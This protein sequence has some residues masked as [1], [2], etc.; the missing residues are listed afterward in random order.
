MCSHSQIRACECV[1]ILLFKSIDCSD[2]HYS[3]PFWER[4]RETINFNCVR[5]QNVTWNENG[6]NVWRIQIIISII[7][8]M[9]YRLMEFED[10]E[11]LFMKREWKWWNCS[12]DERTFNLNANFLTSF[13]PDIVWEK[14]F[15]ETSFVLVVGIRNRKERI[16]LIHTLRVLFRMPFS[17]FSQSNCVLHGSFLFFSLSFFFF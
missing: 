13:L 11:N 9:K 5:M 7:I 17:S 4:K 14:F 8:I 15:P 12:I 1:K 10:D 2:Y 16:V 6:V 3:L